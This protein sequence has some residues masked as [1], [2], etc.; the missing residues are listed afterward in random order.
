M[1]HC[2]IPSL[3]DSNS[4]RTYFPL[5]MFLLLFEAVMSVNVITRRRCDHLGSIGHNPD[6]IPPPLYLL[7]F[8]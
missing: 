4:R 5:V 1:V 7:Y 6:V 2:I 3:A 8:E